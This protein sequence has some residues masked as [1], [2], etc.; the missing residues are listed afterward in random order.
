MKETR[1]LRHSPPGDVNTAV[2]GPTPDIAVHD[3][4]PPGAEEASAVSCVPI[5]RAEGGPGTSL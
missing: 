5:R 1:C 2:P 3:K 4:L